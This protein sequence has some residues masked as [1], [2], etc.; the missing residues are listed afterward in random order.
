MLL[1]PELFIILLMY[2]PLISELTLI[3]VAGLIGGIVSQK[4][5][6]P[7]VTGY[8]VVGILIA[9]VFQDKIRANETI[10]ILA[11]IGI[12]LLLFSVGLEFSID[13]TSKISRPALLGAVV[14]VLVTTFLG[15]IIFPFFLHVDMVS[16]LLLAFGISLS[17]T[18]VVMKILADNNEVRTLH[19]EIM[20]GW[21]IAQDLFVIPVTVI[22]PVLA[23]NQGNLL[24][25]LGESLIKV[26]IVGY[27]MLLLGRK[28]IP[29]VFEKIARLSS[30]EL[31]LTSSFALSL[32]LSHLTQNFLGSFA[33]GAFLGGFILSASSLKYD[34]NVQVRSLRDILAAVFF[35]SIG[36]LLSPSYL[37]HSWWKVLLLTVIVLVIKFV[38]IFWIVRYLGFHSKIAFLVSMGL[39]EV[40][41][42]AFVLARIGY[43]QKIVNEDAYQLMVSTTII[44]LLLTSFFMTKSRHF[45]KISREF[46]KTKSKPLHDMIFNHHDKSMT[47]SS[48]DA[49]ILFDHVILIGYGRVGR[50]ISKV[51]EIS[52]I[53]VVIVDEDYKNLEPLLNTGSYFIYGDAEESEILERANLEK[54]RLAVIAIPD[55]AASEHIIRIIKS[56]NPKLKIIGR[57][58][59]VEDVKKLNGLGVK[60][61]IEPEFEAS[62]S[63]SEVIL[64]ELVGDTRKSRRVLSEILKEHAHA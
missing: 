7:V 55:I 21:L 48:G 41:E 51:L 12:A 20:A 14:Q 49:R 16:S 50:I 32:F 46:I 1:G 27:L 22:I 25:G 54:A 13:K 39:L 11:D 4:L 42:F 38:V 62:V 24:I 8:L 6:L 60:D 40:G 31:M 58:H 10:P 30:K 15:F 63:M 9:A 36:F 45:Y 59:D 47:D 34:I 43:A 17:S 52:K 2:L 29:F 19:G 35:V 28:F 44:S 33:L 37:L 18:S 3:L 5:K 53:G 26:V 23:R 57:A 61:I 64:D 56:I